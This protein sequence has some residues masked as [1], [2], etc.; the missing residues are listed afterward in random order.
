MQWFAQ[1]PSNIAL[2]KYMG[3]TNPETNMPLNPSLSYT[4]NTLLSNVSLELIPG[5]NDYWEPL[6]IPGDKP[7]SLPP[8]AQSR[9]LQHLS[10]L[11]AYFKVDKHF[12]VRSSNN[13]PQA[14]GL[15]S[16]ASSF[17]ALTKCAVIALCELTHQPLLPVDEQARLSRAGSGSSCRSFYAPWALWE[18]DS[19]KAMNLP[20]NNLIH[21]AIIISDKE[22][23]VPS[24]EAHRRVQSSPRYES[25][26]QQAEQHLRLLLNA[27]EVKDW[28]NAYHIC[29]REFHSMHAM[30]ASCAQPFTYITPD[31]QQVLNTIQE[32]WAHEH[33]GPLVTMDAGPNIHLLYRADQAD[34]AQQ[35][36]RDYLVGNY[37]V[38]SH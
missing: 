9:F 8:Q 30:F 27:F 11:K 13:F 3:K 14:S 25:R 26:P 36:R 4:L 24:S 15:A 34:F 5:G 23:I 37:D 22:K 17:A 38:I 31:A 1:A 20:Y 2:I 16:S 6:N 32:L 18:D 29:W 7:F 21:Q 33:D 10:R 12:V 28:E 35:F 19:V